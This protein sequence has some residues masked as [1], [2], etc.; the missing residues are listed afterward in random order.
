MRLYGC[1]R[2]TPYDLSMFWYTELGGIE[3]VAGQTIAGAQKK[4]SLLN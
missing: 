4:S 2:I 3:V 1:S